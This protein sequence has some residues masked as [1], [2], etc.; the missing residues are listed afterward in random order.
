M[1][2]LLTNVVAAVCCGMASTVVC[3]QGWNYIN[4]QKGRYLAAAGDCVSCH[5]VK[6][7]KPFSGGYPV[8]TPFG[9]IYSSNI[10]PDL[11]TGIGLWSND[12]FYQAMHNGVRKDGKQMYPACPYPWFTNMTRADSDALK[13]YLDTLEPVRALPVENELM[14]P[15]GWRGWMTAWN[16]LFFEPGEY[17]PDPDK[18]DLWNRGAYLVRGLGHCAACH[19]PKNMFGASD[20]DQAMQGGDAGESWFAPSL[21][22]HEKDGLG[23]W[24]VDDIVQYLATGANK[25]TASVGPMTEVV[26]NS[27][28]HL[29]KEDLTAIATYLK[30]IPAHEVEP[31][32]PDD[33][34]EQTM[35]RG[36]AVYVDQ[37]MG[38]HMADGKG[39]KGAF[40]PLADSPPIVARQPLSLIQVVLGGEHM[41]DPP[42][43][44]TGLAMPAFGWKLSDQQVA[45]VLTYVRNSWGNAASAVQAENVADVR[46]DLHEYGP[47]FKRLISRQDA[48]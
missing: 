1:S 7:G 26:M 18:P 40:P 29:S 24:S 20:R 9:T 14:W 39:Q 11:E 4:V 31:V 17:V 5:T 8:E 38:C 10:T 48:P 41:A 19:T 3:A 37:C 22:G 30:D 12:D 35:L 2:K 25:D 16:R 34:D 47:R 6:G 43:L 28:S 15:L 23:S 13:T 44:P 33:I 32:D 27:T 45:D 42:A 36:E 21:T 46:S